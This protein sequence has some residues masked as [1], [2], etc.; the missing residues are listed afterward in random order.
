MM[1]L[2]AMQDRQ[3]PR[4]KCRALLG[5]LVCFAL[6]L[7]SCSIKKLAF[8]KIGSALAS[9]G[10]TFSADNDPDLVGSALPFSLKLMEA[11][12]A[13][14]PKHVALLSAASSGFTQYTYIYVQQ[15]AEQIET[16]DFDKSQELRVRSRRLYLR[17]RDYG[18]RGLEVKHPGFA[19]IVREDPRR[20]VRAI[21]AKSDV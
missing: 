3:E 2:I 13:E 14:S 18:L 20:A 6:L 4:H 1:K 7:C 10:T 9:P 12:L 8:N 11:L 19:R 16:Q 21:T 15:Q 5:A 17:G